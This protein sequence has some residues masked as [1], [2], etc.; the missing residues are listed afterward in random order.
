[1]RDGRKGDLFC[2]NCCNFSDL[3]LQPRLLRGFSFVFW[4]FLL[5][6]PSL[7]LFPLLSYHIYQTVPPKNTRRVRDITPQYCPKGVRHEDQE[8][9]PQVVGQESV[10]ISDESHHCTNSGPPHRCRWLLFLSPW[11]GSQDR[12]C[13]RR[14]VTCFLGNLCSRKSDHEEHAGQISRQSRI[15]KWLIPSR[16]TTLPISPTPAFAGVFLLPKM[17]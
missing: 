3:I 15:K 6:F 11:T 2:G 7:D 12:V 8:I 14:I 13:Y 10:G 5:L 1:M 4:L 17:V 16:L 9:L